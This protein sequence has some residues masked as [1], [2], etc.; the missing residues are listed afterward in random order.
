MARLTLQL[1]SALV[2][3]FGGR[4]RPVTDWRSRSL[5]EAVLNVL[6]RR[7]DSRRVHRGGSDQRRS[8]TLCDEDAQLL[9]AVGAR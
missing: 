8:D 7:L 4:R 1:G 2:V 9:F 6:G 3:P 5:A